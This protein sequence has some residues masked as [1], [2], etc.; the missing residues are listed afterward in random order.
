MNLD[1]VFK[2]PFITNNFIPTTIPFHS[3][4]DICV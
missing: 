2:K 1:N 4:C 3:T